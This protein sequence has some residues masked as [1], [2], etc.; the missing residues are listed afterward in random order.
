VNTLALALIA[1]VAAPDSHLPACEVV[2]KPANHWG[3]FQSK[4]TSSLV[5]VAVKQGYH[6]CTF[7]NL[8]VGE[9]LLIDP[10][11]FSVQIDGQEQWLRVPPDKVARLTFEGGNFMC[12]YHN[13]IQTD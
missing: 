1:L 8:E 5:T 10:A 6:E 7:R 4:F 2:Q 13:P 3:Q 12:R 11:S 9:C